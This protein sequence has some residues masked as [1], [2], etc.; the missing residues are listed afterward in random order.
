MNVTEKLLE[1]YKK[2]KKPFI[3][4]GNIKFPDRKIWTEEISLLKELEN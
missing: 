1:S 4:E 3:T 2:D